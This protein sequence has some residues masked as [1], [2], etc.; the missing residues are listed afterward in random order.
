MFA[1][2]AG[3]APYPFSSGSARDSRIFRIDAAGFV[4]PCRGPE[5]C[6]TGLPKLSTVGKTATMRYL[7]LGES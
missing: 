7:S 5:P 3:S 4:V 1:L 6:V 2:A